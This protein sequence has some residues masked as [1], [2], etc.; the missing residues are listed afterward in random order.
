M[1][2]LYLDLDTLRPDHLGCYGY[3]RDT[4]P[5]IDRVAAEG[6]RFENC[7][8]SDAPCLP[9]RT[10]L[11]SGRFGIHT[12]VVG[13][14]GTASE[15]RITGP[16]RDFRDT[17]STDSLPAFLKE[18]KGFYTV[19][20]GGF[21]ERHASWSFYAGFREILDT[22]KWGGESAE[23]VTPTVLNWIGRN[24]SRDNWY[25]HVNYWDPHT[26]YR[27]PRDFG[28]PFADKSLPTWFTPELIKRHRVL[29]GPHTAQDLMMY[30]NL[31]D[32]RFP[33]HPGEIKNMDDL[34]L[35]IDG[36]DCGVRYMD[37]HIG[38]LFDALEKAGVLQDTAIIISGDHGENLGELG[39]YAEHATADYST[40][41]IPMIIR[42]PGGRQGHIDSGFHYN[43]D[44]APT[45]AELFQIK[46]RFSW[47][48]RSYAQTILGGND[49][50][51]PYLVIS[52][53]THVCQRGVRWGSWQYIRTWHDGWHLF[54]KEMLFN[55]FE[56]SHEEHDLATSKPDLC[57]E[58][59]YKLL[60][61]YDRMMDTMPDGYNVDPME[62]VLAEGGP[63]HANNK[64]LEVYC[65]R[66]K[67]SGRE[68]AIPELKKRHSAKFL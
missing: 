19:F 12:G 30:D 40:C 53:C 37:E 45:L 32:S 36:Y 14:G 5:N 35:L 54:P 56:D 17:L 65:E 24:A 42:W 50:G 38:M 34:R 68:W 64:L 20:I 47:E 60:E 28:N 63:F 62:M 66:L 41:R 58:G 6:V 1:R 49:C 10:A 3:H 61:W 2:I 9:S 26:P 31:P 57:H 39:I 55:V 52:Q 51:H 4:S 33:R 22:G 18:Q 46:P 48:G 44:L 67:N 59:A 25:L 11:M 23:D 16:K 27:A 29:P 13:H 15:M 8:C 43:L 7:Y 21:G